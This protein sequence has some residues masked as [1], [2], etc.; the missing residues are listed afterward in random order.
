MPAAIQASE[1]AP[2]IE[3]LVS[4]LRSD[5]SLRVFLETDFRPARHVGQA[6][7]EERVQAAL[8]EAQRAQ[9]MLSARVRDEVIRRKEAL[10]AEVEAVAALE[11]EVSTVANG[12]QSLS[13]ASSALST[14]LLAPHIPM[15]RAVRRMN[16]LCAAADL[17]AAVAR[18]RY[19]TGK[20]KDAGLFPTIDQSIASNPAVLTP[21]AEA[22]KELEGLICS[23]GPPGLEKVDG[24]AKSIVAI[25]KASP[26]LRRRAAAMLKSGLA[27]RNQVDVEAAVTAFYSLGVLS[28]RVNSE[29]SRLLSETNTAL[30]RG[31][32]APRGLPQSMSTLSTP[33][34]ASGQ[35]FASAAER[36]VSRNIQVWNNVQKMFDAIADTCCK[37][38]LLQQVLSKK[39]CDV[40]HLSLLQEPLASAFI[41]DVALALAEQIAVL[42]RTRHQRPSANIVFLALAEGFPKLRSSILDVVARVDAL[43]R[44]SPAP[45]TNLPPDPK[46]PFVPSQ[47]F[48]SEAFLG[49]VVDLETHYLTASLERL[50]GAVTASF[51]RHLQPNESDALALARLLATELSAARSDGKLLETAVSNVA[52]A[53]RLYKS[54]AEDYAAATAPD[55]DRKTSSQASKEWHLMSLY[56]AMVTLTT[57]ARRVLGANDDGTG[58]LPPPI[59][60]E[61]SDLSVLCDRFLDGPFSQC[62]SD[63]LDSLRRMHT[64]D[65]EGRVGDDGCSVY[66]MDIA[67]QLSLFTDNTISTLARSRSLG[68]N[69]VDL[70]TWV[71]DTFI[72]YV[73]MVCPTSDLKR[74]RLSTDIARLELA[75]ETLCAV[76][77][78]GVSYKSLRAVRRLLLVPIEDVV[79]SDETL[80]TDLRG[81]S[82]SAVARLLMS[83]SSD[84]RLQLPHA[85]KRMSSDDYVSW[86]EKHTEDEAWIDIEDSMKAYTRN[87]PSESTDEYCTEYNVLTELEATL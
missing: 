65:L 30:H 5:A 46:R 17:L 83:R 77:L 74:M 75:V 64:E 51:S 31:L 43:A 21:A 57:C 56:N 32:E 82:K 3:Q 59:A 87:V 63:I 15:E 42:T 20:L 14:A 11:R 35:R 62:R 44:L 7:R 72:A 76:R 61:V 9:S 22:L 16:N 84:E 18:F 8:Q 12:V 27:E 52:T 1:K 68:K 6:V 85:R 2:E 37:A 80:V 86:L 54:H 24:V 13:D 23:T 40:S 69:T 49:A 33:P 25:R 47:V 73:S 34:N 26:E 66:I 29:I 53:L 67:A 58:P 19:C 78:L 41:S 4:G 55:S 71:V 10:L 28:D 50:T 48:I 38:I 45:I 36:N 81:A 70:A 39:Y 79:F 60:R